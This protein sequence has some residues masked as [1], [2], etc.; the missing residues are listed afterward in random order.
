MYRSAFIL[1]M[2]LVSLQAAQ[3]QQSI[4]FAQQQF[5]QSR[6]QS[7]VKTYTEYLE[8]ISKTP[9]KEVD[10]RDSYKQT[11][12]LTMGK[13]GPRTLIYNDLIPPK[14]LQ[15]NPSMEKS[16]QMEAYINKMPEHYGQ[17]LSLTYSNMDVSEVF[18]S[19]TDNWYFVKVT[20]TRKID[21]VYQHGTEQTP[22]QGEDKVDFFVY[23][24]MINNEVKMGGIYGVQ[25]HSQANNYIKV[26][27]EGGAI[28]GAPIVG[29]PI[30]VKKE[31]IRGNYKRGKEYSIAWEGGLADD[32][33]QVDLVAQDSTRAKPKSFGAMLN[34]NGLSFIPSK[35]NKVGKYQF[36]IK[37]I[38]TGRSTQTGYFTIRRTIP[39][40]GKIAGSILIPVAG[41]VAY[42]LWIEPD[43][44][45]NL[46]DP[47]KL[48]R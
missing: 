17:N 42:K 19:Q 2:L 10:L 12:F 18:Y 14:V 25:P 20:A 22:Y 48:P 5:M 44:E 45:D 24:N 33:I 3:A 26:K 27:V 31:T 29:K 41:Y 11:V 1:I 46:P 35:A 4:T 30:R 36:K 21:G 15:S 39:L 23:A 43:S 13:E 34:R 40:A 8:L 38:S 7:K 16:V 37:N 28:G 6:A 32:I 47:P 9:G